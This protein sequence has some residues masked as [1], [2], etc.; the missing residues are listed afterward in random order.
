MGALE[1]I[2]A[3][4]MKKALKTLLLFFAP[5][6][7]LLLL[8]SPL[9]AQCLTQFNTSKN[10]PNLISAKVD[11]S[12]L[13]ENRGTL[14]ALREKRAVQIQNFRE[15]LHQLNRRSEDAARKALYRH[16]GWDAMLAFELFPQLELLV[17][18]GK[19]SFTSQKQLMD[20]SRPSLIRAKS[21][22]LTKEEPL[23][24]WIEDRFAGPR[25][26]GGLGDYFRDFKIHS[27]DLIASHQI[28]ED[29]AYGL[30]PKRITRMGSHG[31]VVFR[32]AGK[33]RTVLYL[34]HDATKNLSLVKTLDLLEDPFN[35]IFQRAD[36]K[37]PW[38]LKDL[39]MQFK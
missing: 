34:H 19:Q 25:L 22:L 3:E 23:F 14:E 10:S 24:E 16:G 5:V 31:L 6:F 2:L 28:Y 17:I 26:I 7:L 35:V 20:S 29:S 8:R 9:W 11:L 36:Q 30:S 32:G 38:H 27:L 33:K 18:T 1:G 12:A 15:S 39:Q 21:V 4:L 37:S 13:V